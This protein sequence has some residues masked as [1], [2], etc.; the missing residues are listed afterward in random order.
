MCLCFDGE[1]A[2]VAY[3]PDE[4]SE[5]QPAE[6]TSASRSAEGKASSAVQQRRGESHA[7]AGIGSGGI[8][9]L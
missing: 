1:G 2:L 6:S 9:P 5:S 4:C 3:Q 7:F 8:Y